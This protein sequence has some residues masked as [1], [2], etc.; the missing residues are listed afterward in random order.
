MKAQ[1]LQEANHQVMSATR[2]KAFM[3]KLEQRQ[4][5]PGVCV[6]AFVCV[7]ARVCVCVFVC[8]AVWDWERDIISVVQLTL[9]GVNGK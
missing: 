7:C 3:Q 2:L 5:A 6:C 9:D 8:V 4:Q 1:A